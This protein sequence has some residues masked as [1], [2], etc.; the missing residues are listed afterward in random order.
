MCVVD[1]LFTVR[2]RFLFAMALLSVLFCILVPSASGVSSREGAVS[3]VSEA[4]QSIAQVYEAVVDAES[5]GAN[6]SSLLVGLNDAVGLLSE[7]QLA[8]EVGD[9]EECIRLA[10]LSREAGSGVGN[11]ARALE[12]EANYAYVNLSWWFAGGSVLGVSVVILASFFGY[13]YFKRWYY[14]RLLKMKPTVGQA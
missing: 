9:F 13:R 5:A 8:L 6:V 2:L 4:E 10:E 14:Q 11:E 12:V 3:T 7:A 1:V